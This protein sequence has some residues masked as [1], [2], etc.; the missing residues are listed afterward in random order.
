MFD[1]KYLF[2]VIEFSQKLYSYL[3]TKDCFWEQYVHWQGGGLLILINEV[4]RPIFVLLC[5][6]FKKNL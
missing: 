3:D 2:G 6:E 5:Y 4:A 1:P